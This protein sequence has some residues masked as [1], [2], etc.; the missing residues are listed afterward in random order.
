[1]ALSQILLHK[2]SFYGFHG[3][4]LDL[5]KSYLSNRTQYVDLNDS[6]SD[7]LP[8]TCGVPQGSTLGPLF[9]IIYVNDLPNNTDSF[10]IIIYADDT[11][12]FATLCQKD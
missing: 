8:I 1:M 6:I 3:I 12:L 4:P 11:T 7:T 5:I 10:K 2:L 9:F